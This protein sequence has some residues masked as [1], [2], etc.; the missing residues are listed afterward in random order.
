MSRTL[1]PCRSVVGRAALVACLTLGLSSRTLAQGPS[2]P[3]DAGGTAPSRDEVAVLRDEVADLR[4]Q[5]QTLAAEMRALRGAAASASRA[6]AAA[7]SALASSS[8]LAPQEAPAQLP[9]EMLQA[10]VQELA[11]VKVE[12]A[13]R[14]PVRLSGTIVSNTVVNSGDANWLESPNLVGTASGGSM[15]STMRQSRVG[16]DVHS[17]AVGGWEAKGTLIVDFMGGTPGF[18]TGTVMGLPRLL[19]AFGRLERG[20]TAVQAGQDHAMLAPRDPTSLAAF[21]FPQFF[22]TGNLYLRAPQV[23]VEQR[24]GG[25]TAKAGIIAPIAGDA[26]GDYVFAPTAGQGERSERP[27]YE[28]HLGYGR[29]AADDRAEVQVGVSGHAGWLKQ[30]GALQRTTAGAVDFNARVGRLGLAGEVFAAQDLDAFGTGVAQPGRAEGGWVEARFAALRRV[31]VNGGAAIDRR[32]DG[33]GAAGRLRN[34]SAFGNVIVRFTPEVAASVEYKWLGTQYGSGR[35][36]DN[37]HVNAVFAV[38]F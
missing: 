33:V 15:T 37:H 12:S 13:S 24:L 34:R 6:D 7:G 23:R 18:V 38:T 8:R 20:G 17:I 31:S 29:G 30:A 27:A 21:A 19:Y 1:I 22:R 5:L 14:F 26:S 2:A 36:R 3:T 28:G 9:P 4:Q 32:P 11:Q 16:L 25:F 35:T 10:Q